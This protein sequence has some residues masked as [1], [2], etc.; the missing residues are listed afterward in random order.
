[1]PAGTSLRQTDTSRCIVYG[2]GSSITA[3]LIV[4]PSVA[5]EGDWWGP[6]SESVAK[7]MV[8][9]AQGEYL[10]EGDTCA[11]EHASDR[12]SLSEAQSRS[13]KP[14]EDFEKALMPQET[15]EGR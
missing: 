12:N 14:T 1:M 15:P 10:F 3:L 11:A 13:Q 4:D 5:Q 6:Y 9:A 7:D 8:A 2:H